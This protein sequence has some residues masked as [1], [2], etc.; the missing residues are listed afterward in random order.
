VRYLSIRPLVLWY[1]RGVMRRLLLAEIDKRFAEIRAKE[2]GGTRSRSVLALALQTYLDDRPKGAALDADFR[3]AV[4]PQ[5]CLFLFAGH[6]TTGTT[7]VY[8]YHLLAQNPAALARL[9]A[10]HDEVFGRDPAQ[11]QAA[12]SADPA[13]LNSIPYTLGVIKEVLRLHS[14]ASVLRV[15]RAGVSVVDDDG[16]QYSTE[17]C[18]VW[19]LNDCLQRNER[20]WED[21]DAFRPERWLVGPEDPLYPPKHA[22]RPFSAGPRNCIGQSLAMLE[23][24]TVLVMTAREFDVQAAYDEWDKTHPPGKR[25]VEHRG[26]RVYAAEK[27]GGG[28]HPASGYPCRVTLRK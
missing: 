21:A 9:R 6:D 13:K 2:A 17:G 22:W 12:I 1:N 27:G 4:A 11:A 19:V 14:P 15:G 23:L 10:E 7:L 16:A 3:A 18:N 28:L 5:L 25:I 24:K 20:Y 8:C 26:S